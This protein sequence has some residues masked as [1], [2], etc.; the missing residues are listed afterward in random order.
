MRSQK[1]FDKIFF[2]HLFKLLERWNICP[3]I[4]AGSLVNG[5]NK[6][7][8]ITAIKRKDFAAIKVTLKQNTNCFFYISHFWCFEAFSLYQFAL[9]CFSASC[10]AN[11]LSL[12]QMNQPSKIE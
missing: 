3:G 7:I 11:M 5:V 2:I 10:F 4:R 6:K 1:I 8:S 12:T 9:E